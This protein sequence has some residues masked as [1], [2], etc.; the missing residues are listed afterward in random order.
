MSEPSW[1]EQ[2]WKT[3]QHHYARA[4]YFDALD[5]ARF[6]ELIPW[7]RGK[8]TEPDQLPIFEGDLRHPLGH[9]DAF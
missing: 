4:P 7:M 8:A 6:E 9:P 3:L 5:R 2:H 1:K